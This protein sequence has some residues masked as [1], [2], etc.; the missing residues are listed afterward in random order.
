MPKP[1]PVRRGKPDLISE[2][3]SGK[4]RVS[5]TRPGKTY[6]PWRVQVRYAGFVQRTSWHDRFEVALADA[7]QAAGL[8]TPVIPLPR[9]VVEV[10]LAAT[11]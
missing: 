9:P 2:L 7:L 6:G 10:D 1:D 3:F 5:V 8:A 4:R 11:P